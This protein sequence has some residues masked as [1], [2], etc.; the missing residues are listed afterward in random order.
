V[1]PSTGTFAAAIGRSS[2]NDPHVGR[3]GGPAG[4]AQLTAW[5]GLMLLVLSLIELATLLD[6]NRW[7]SWHI[8]VGALLL[9]PALL[10][11][12]ST[13]WR[14]VRYYTGNRDYQAA[15]PPP[16]LL[17][18]LGPLTVVTT[19]G[20]LGSGIALVAVGP[21]QSRDNLVT[22]LGQRIDWVTLH[23]ALFIGWAVATGLHVL[24]RLVPAISLT[25][26]RGA[27]AER[28]SGGAGR[29]AVW[30]LAAGSSALTAVLLLHAAGAWR[31]GDFGFHH[32][33]RDRTG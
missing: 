30:A 28:V 3:T 24:G 12:G 10:K 5:T 7:I 17:R 32:F 19:L 8:V 33:G 29:V 11:T 1:I 4:N 15:G 18:L 13:G 6:V 9:P 2:R 16:L 26:A 23:Q 25:V 31:N 27:T 21:T 14:I 22:L 20:V